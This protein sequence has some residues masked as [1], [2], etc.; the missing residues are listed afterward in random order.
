MRFSFALIFIFCSGNSLFAQFNEDG[1]INNYEDKLIVYNDL[2]F[3]ASPFTIKS[4]FKGATSKLNYSHNFRLQYGFGFSYRWFNLHLNLPLPVYTKALSRYGE[5]VT[6]GIQFNLNPKRLQF[7][8]DAKLIKG[9]AIKNAY[10]YNDSLNELSPNTVQPS[11]KLIYFGTK[12]WYFGNENFKLKYL[13]GMTSVYN[14]N[15]ISWFANTAFRFNSLNDEFGITPSIIQNDTVSITKATKFSSGE[16]SF[17]PGFS[18]VFVHNNLQFSL[19]CGLGG[20][21]QLKQYVINENN[22]TF[23]GLVPRYEVGIN[24]GYSETNYFIFLTSDFEN[25]NL[26]WKD[27]KY[28]QFYYALKIRIGYRFKLNKN[29]KKEALFKDK[30]I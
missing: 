22:R 13:N 20:A 26:N 12:A 1:A 25:I 9:F 3:S 8:I 16:L 6:Y 7:E 30:S 28:N 27:L 5:N 21:F 15:V 18:G 2:G 17:I 29:D 19:I 23:L 24:A 10:Y 11:T 14:Q 4:D